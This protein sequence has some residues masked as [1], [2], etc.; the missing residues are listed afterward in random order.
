M[1]FL[2]KLWSKAEAPIRPIS[3]IHTPPQPARL[4]PPVTPLRHYSEALNTVDHR[5]PIPAT[6][7]YVHRLPWMFNRLQLASVG[8]Y[9]CYNAGLVLFA[10]Q[11]AAS[12]SQTHN[13]WGPFAAGYPPIY[14][15]GEKE[16]LA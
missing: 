13:V 4:V 9:I 15:S 7:L 16:T 2:R 14:R 10:R 1:S 12:G 8:W 6:G 3:P 11:H 5:T